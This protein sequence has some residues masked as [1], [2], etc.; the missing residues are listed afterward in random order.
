VDQVEE[1]LPSNRRI[2]I[3]EVS[4]VVGVPFGSIQSILNVKWPEKVEVG[5]LKIW[6]LVHW[7]FCVKMHLLTLLCLDMNFWL[8]LE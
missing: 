5:G 8:K 2:A 7:F 4:N 1:L 6:N 3:H